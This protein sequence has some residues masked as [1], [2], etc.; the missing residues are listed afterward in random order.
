[1]ITATNNHHETAIILHDL[2]LINTERIAGY[3]L[4]I[5]KC[6]HL[7]IEFKTLI[8]RIIAESQLNQAQLMNKIATLGINLSNAITTPGIIYKAWTDLKSTFTGSDTITFFCQYNEDLAQH[9]YRVALNMA[10]QF[11]EDIVRMLESQQKLLSKTYDLIKNCDAQHYFNSRNV[12][13]T[14]FKPDYYHIQN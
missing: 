12:R 9:A 13:T 14:A 11:D 8:K 2:M 10:D 7:S 6:E 3:Q 4:A 5:V 1:M